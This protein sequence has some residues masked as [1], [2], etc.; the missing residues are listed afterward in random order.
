M[1]AHSKSNIVTR[2]GGLLVVLI[3]GRLVFDPVLV[4][5]GQLRT[6]EGRFRYVD[7][8]GQRRQVAL[9]PGTFAFTLRDVLVVAHGAGPAFLAVIFEDG[10]IASQEGLALD[11]E[12][13]AQVLAGGRVRR[14]DAFLGLKL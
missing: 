8:R 2:V 11:R 3:D 5:P 14:L 7:S 6:S 13:S 9:A 4:G 12:T 1:A 10:S